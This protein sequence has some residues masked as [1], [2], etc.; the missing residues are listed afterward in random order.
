MP[1]N[2][3][4]LIID[5]PHNLKNGKVIPVVGNNLIFTP[6]CIIACNNIKLAE[7]ININLEVLL[8]FSI[9]TFFKIE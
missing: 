9:S 2:I 1:D 3:E 7:P 5:D 4:T 6:I 8:L